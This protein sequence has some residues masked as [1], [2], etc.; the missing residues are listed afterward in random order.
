M[1]VQEY[2]GRRTAR[3][4]WWNTPNNHVLGGRDLHRDVQGTWLGMT[5][6]GRIAILTN[7]RE[8]DQVIVQGRRSRGEM[9]LA[10]LTVPQ[11]STETPDEFAKRMVEEEGVKG[12]GGFSLIFGQISGSES[13]LGII[14]NRT[15]N[16]EG[17]IWITGGEARTSG[18]ICALSNSH[19][20]DR[21]WPKV[22]QGERLAAAAIKESLGLDETQDELLVRLF[23]VLNTDSLPKQKADE[24]WTTFVKEL[25]KS[26]L[27]PPI[28]G[29]DTT[30]TSADEI[31]AAKNDEPLNSSSSGLYGTS[32]QTVILVHRSGKTTFVERTL[33]DEYAQRIPENLQDTKFEFQIEGADFIQI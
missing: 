3:S 7:Y 27:I 28:G 32:Q 24:G 10:Y 13:K 4:A 1:S 30:H 19:F 16:A 9:P 20:G 12:V 14:S 21:T 25:R 11:H 5:R 33:F 15:S 8:D 23:R 31:A 6:Q 17:V 22:V 18:Q 26:I 29:T 2:L